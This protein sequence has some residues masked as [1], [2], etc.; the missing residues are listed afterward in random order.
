[1][2]KQETID[3]L[4]KQLPGFY[5]VEQVI[6]MVNDI[7]EPEATAI[8]PLTQFQIESLTKKIIDAVTDNAENVGD[9]CIDKD[10]AEFSMNYN[11]CVELDCVGFDNGRIVDAVLDGIE[12]V[13][14]EWFDK[15]FPESEEEVS[16]DKNS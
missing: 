7:E 14:G 8:N 5:S 2:T 9:D 12:D 3:L 15:A 11:N 1:M 10:S 16:E 6:K 13:I 4:G